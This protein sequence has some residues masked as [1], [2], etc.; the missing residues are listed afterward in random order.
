MG[1]EPDGAPP[2]APES[3]WRSS[4]RA[5]LATALGVAAVALLSQWLLPHSAYTVITSTLFT[6]DTWLHEDA[7]TAAF[8]SLSVVWWLGARATGCR[9]YRLL[10]IGVMWVGSYVVQAVTFIGLLMAA[11]QIPLEAGARARA[12]DLVAL[13]TVYLGIYIW[14]RTTLSRPVHEI[15]SAAAS[16]RRVYGLGLAVAVFALAT[17]AKAAPCGT[18]DCRADALRTGL[19]EDVTRFVETYVR[20]SPVIT[21]D[22]GAVQRVALRAGTRSRVEVWMDYDA[23]LFLEVEGD[24][25]SGMLDLSLAGNSYRD[26]SNSVGWWAAGGQRVPLD[27]KGGVDTIKRRAEATRMQE[28]ELE[29]ARATSDC[30]AML[31]I[32]ARNDDA[33]RSQTAFRFEQREVSLWRAE[34]AEKT[35]DRRQAANAYALYASRLSPMAFDVQPG[36]TASVRNAQRFLDKAIALDPD[37]PNRRWWDA[38]IKILRV[39]ERFAQDPTDHALC[40]E[41]KQALAEGH[42]HYTKAC[43]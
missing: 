6:R 17:L 33:D 28:V 26:L 35:G 32:I 18:L 16:T 1:E 3:F 41:L 27:N 19:G 15:P 8:F 7:W 25:G 34:C 9:T 4:R 38:R 24:R 12:T 42:T 37:S 39:Q 29:A 30:A 21:Q 11:N 2:T 31:A 36:D 14:M 22:I 23:E 13:A 20:E 10:P 43:M 5:P 40:L